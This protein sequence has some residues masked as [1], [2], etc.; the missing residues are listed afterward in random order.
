[1]IEILLIINGCLRTLCDL[2]HHLNSLY[3]IFTCRTFAGQHDSTCTIVDCIC[4]VCCLR[5]CRARVLN[6]GIEHLCRRDN[7]L[8]RH[9]YL[10]D[11]H[12]LDDRNFLTRN[13]HTHI[14][15]GNHDSIRYIDDI[16]DM[17]HALRILDFGN[18]V[19]IISAVGIQQLTDF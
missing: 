3:R 2:R 14:S 6:H 4:N 19:N 12:L 13:L 16:I 15:T 18:D 9:I 1:M 10:I 11:D 17:I 8:A 7:L 5:T